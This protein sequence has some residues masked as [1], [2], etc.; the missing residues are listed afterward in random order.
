MLTICLVTQ[1]R[2]E[3]H[4]FFKSAGPLSIL[5]HVNFLIIDNGSPQDISDEISKWASTQ[6]RVTVVRLQTNTTDF[7]EIWS[8][9][10]MYCSE[11]V[12]F[13]GD[14]DRLIF[15]GI[16]Q[17]RS[18]VFDRP[19][20]EVTAMSAKIIDQDGVET[21]EIAGPDYVSVGDKASQVA[22]GLH[23]PPFFWPTLFFK[24]SLI[25]GPFP[26]SRFVLD[27][28][29]SLNLLIKA[30]VLE[31]S[32]C[33]LA[34]RR[35]ALQESNLVSLNRKYFEGIYH[36]DDFLNSAFFVTWIDSMN[37]EILADFWNAVY[38]SPPIYAERDMANVLLFRIAKL[39]IAST[40][41]AHLH[42]QVLADL[43]LA[44]GS[45]QHDQGFTDFVSVAEESHFGNL[46]I[47]NDLKC[48]FLGPLVS[49]FQGSESAYPVTIFCEHGLK[50][51]GSVFIQCGKYQ[52]FTRSIQRDVLVREISE[53][54]E[55][56]GLLAFRISS[57]ERF[58]VMKLRKYKSLL[59][60]RLISKLRRAI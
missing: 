19:D 20:V 16:M 23:A 11:W 6:P 8:S 26:H 45:L 3:V 4:E 48:P 55:E 28:W 34:Y 40:H 36:L 38:K 57:R 60:K 56:A 25:R 46:R 35:H 9:V 17:W 12:T 50:T 13:P 22:R 30:E 51:P 29:I 21:G 42:N 5:E 10:E 39:V 33:T 2:K 24:K 32:V 41:S 58:T 54:L 31:S 47:I 43:A 15:E 7:N 14:D 52:N 27:W 53:K 49:D 37:K 1:G 44:F 18:I 59:P